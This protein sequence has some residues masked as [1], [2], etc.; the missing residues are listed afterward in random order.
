MN[1]LKTMAVVLISGVF[2]TAA[3]AKGPSGGGGGGGG[4]GGMGGGQGGMGGQSASAGQGGGGQGMSGGQGDQ[5]R[6]QTR[7]PASNP[8]GTPIQDRDRIHTPGTGLTTTPT[9]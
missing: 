3:F 5:L 2:A 6:T 4:M 7:D 1:A 9:N 8:T